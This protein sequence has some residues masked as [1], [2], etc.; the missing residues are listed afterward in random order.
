[1]SDQQLEVHDVEGLRPHYAKTLGHLERDLRASAGRGGR[2]LLRAHGAHLAHLPGGMRARVRAGLGLDLPD[3]RL[4][5]DAAGA[6]RSAAHAGLDV[7]HLASSR[8]PAARG[9]RW[10]PGSVEWPRCSS[11]PTATSI[12]RSCGRPRRRAARM[13]RERRH[14]RAHHQHDAADVPG[15]ARRGR[16][17]Q[18]TCGA[19]RACIRTSA[20]T[21]G[22][23][24]ST[25]WSR[26]AD[27]PKVVGHRRD[28]PRLLSRRG[29]H[30]VAARAL[31]R[32]TS[33]PR[34]RCGKPLV[35]HTRC[36]RAGHAAHH[37]RGGR[38][39]GGRRHALLHRDL[40]GGRGR[41]GAWASTSRS[42]ASSPSRTPGR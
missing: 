31:P 18:P 38:G 8:R 42:P 4:E 7:P 2:R 3:S 41:D 1:M 19:R 27:D 30:R 25:S 36:G 15:R 11:I 35:I 26:M 21:S 34:A 5:A 23:S 12:S 32:R 17:S 37:A 22:R 28:R 33:A 10:I 20:A 40:G 9:R 14:A 16:R 24:R 39:R 13:A 6:R 29:R